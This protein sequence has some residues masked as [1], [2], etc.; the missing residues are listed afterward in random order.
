MA[1]GRIDLLSRLVFSDTCLPL[2][3]VAPSAPPFP[4]VARPGLGIVSIWQAQGGLCE[5]HG[6]RGLNKEQA[7][8]SFAGFGIP[9]KASRSPA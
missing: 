5:M 7:A 9:L 8:L 1:L 4:K 6:I 3:Q 2:A